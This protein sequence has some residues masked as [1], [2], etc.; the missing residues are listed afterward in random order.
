MQPPIA[1]IVDDEADF[2]SVLGE[3][4]VDEG[5]RI[6]E[7]ANGD[8]AMTVLSSLTPD[9]ILIDLLMPVVNGWSLFAMIEE[10]QE[11]RTVPIV[12]LSAVAHMAPGGGSLVLKKPL[13]LP[14]LMKLLD[15]LRPGAHSSEMRLKTSPRTTPSYHLCDAKRRR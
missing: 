1:L 5:Y 14:E 12:F 2:R 8:E 15:A 7:A 13:D 6:V 3:L 11:L 10:R 9:V 4:L